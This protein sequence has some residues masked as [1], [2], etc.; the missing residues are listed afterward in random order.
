[1]ILIYGNPDLRK[2]FL[3]TPKEQRAA[4]LKAY[5][6]LREDLQA[7]GEYIVS[8]ALADPS[9]GRQVAVR[10]GRTLVSDGPYAEVKEYLAGFFL[11]DCDS[12]ERAA[13]YAARVPEAAFGLVEVRPVMELGGFL[14]P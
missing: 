4:G 6:R 7:S 12:P 10:E 11:I 2:A 3:D 9:A 5:D 14:E 8:E 1:M 13:E